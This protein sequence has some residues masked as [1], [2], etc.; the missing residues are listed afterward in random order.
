MTFAYHLLGVSHS[1]PPSPGPEVISPDT[2]ISLH[3]TAN[4]LAFAILSNSLAMYPLSFP[5]FSKSCDNHFLSRLASLKRHHHPHHRTAIRAYEAQDAAMEARAAALTNMIGQ[6]NTTL[7]WPT[8]AGGRHWGGEQPY[9]GPP[10]IR[11][12]HPAGPCSTGVP[13]S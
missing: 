5:P 4:F 1:G 9:R 7:L 8:R 13:R 6:K 2:H 3:A 10:L 12:R 11:N